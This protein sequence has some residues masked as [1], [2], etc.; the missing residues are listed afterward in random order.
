MRRS[1][2]R[3]FRE[4]VRETGNKTV[5]IPKVYW[6]ATE[7]DFNLMVMDL[8]GPSLEDLFSHCKRRF[9]LKTVIMIGEQLV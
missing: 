8:L 3:Y 9:N 7:G 2:T 5:G 4:E 1:C 6:Y